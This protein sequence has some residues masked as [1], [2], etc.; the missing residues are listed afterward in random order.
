MGMIK[1]LN[2]MAKLAEAA[3]KLK[4]QYDERLENI[5][6]DHMTKILDWAWIKA[7]KETID[8]G[9]RYNLPKCPEMDRVQDMYRQKK[10]EYRVYDLAADNAIRDA[11]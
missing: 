9:L 8:I 5:G 4:A 6:N 3:E 1:N 10:Q 11:M 7:T 2:R